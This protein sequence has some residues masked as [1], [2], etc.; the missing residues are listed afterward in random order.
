MVNSSIN[1][2]MANILKNK[3]SFENKLLK[4]SRKEWRKEKLK[5]ARKIGMLQ[6][7]LT[8]SARTSIHIFFS[9][10]AW[11]DDISLSRLLP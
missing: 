6:L 9:I 5:E 10:S 1:M 3:N 4:R 11:Y 7:S 8:K 2:T